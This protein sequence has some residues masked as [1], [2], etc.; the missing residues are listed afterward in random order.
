[1]KNEKKFFV[2]QY[3][4]NEIDI[5]TLR[6]IYDDFTTTIKKFCDHGVVFMP[7]ILQL[8]EMTREELIEVRNMLND[9]L[10][11]NND[12]NSETGTGSEDCSRTV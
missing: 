3:P 12:T 6:D 7:D 8:K 2:V 11:N 9:M 4:W 10:E 5:M 1:M